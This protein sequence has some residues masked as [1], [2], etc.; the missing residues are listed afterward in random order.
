[1]TKWLATLDRIER[2]VLG[3]KAPV[4]FASEAYTLREHIALV[5]RAVLSRGAESTAA[6]NDSGASTAK[7][8]VSAVR[9]ADTAVRS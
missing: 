4:S 9:A 6:E 2:A 7:E 3:V 1:M 8:H 5:R